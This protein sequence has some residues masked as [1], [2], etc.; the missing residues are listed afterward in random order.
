M[1]SIIAIL[2]LSIG[3][4][5][6]VLYVFIQ[7]LI[8]EPYKN[9]TRF[10]RELKEGCPTFYKAYKKV[11]AMLSIVLQYVCNTLKRQVA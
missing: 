6:G 11:Q 8:I 10:K 2:G 3:L 1:A 5:V 7:A 4:V 9:P